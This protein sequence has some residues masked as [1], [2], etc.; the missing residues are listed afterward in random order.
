MSSGGLGVESISDFL[1]H[2]N[3]YTENIHIISNE[4]IWDASGKATGIKEPIIHCANK[5]ETAIQSFPKIFERVQS[6]PNVLL[7]GDSI[8]DI[9]MVKGFA[10]TRLL[11]IGFC[12]PARSQDKKRFDVRLDPD[13]SL[14]SVTSIIQKIIPTKT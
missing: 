10:Y 11:T 14:E 2:E 12:K 6:R 7:L 4:F 1:R 5:D 8:D 13:A 9:G 3:A